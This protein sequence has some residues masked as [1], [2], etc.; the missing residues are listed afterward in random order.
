MRASPSY[1]SP[2]CKSYLLSNMHKR[3]LLGHV[4]VYIYTCTMHILSVCHDTHK[5]NCVAL[6]CLSC[7]MSTPYDAYVAMS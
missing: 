6:L 2:M 1:E 5:L 7:V 4:Y 3:E